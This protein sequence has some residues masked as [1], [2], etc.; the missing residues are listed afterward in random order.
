MFLKYWK[1][2]RIRIFTGKQRD[3]Q[4]RLFPLGMKPELGLQVLP[5]LSEDVKRGY[6]TVVL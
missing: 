5:V 6:L 4:N 1:I 3:N 2:G